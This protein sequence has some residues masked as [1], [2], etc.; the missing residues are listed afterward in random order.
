MNYCQNSPAAA[1][2]AQG[3]NLQWF[4]QQTGGTGSTTAPVPQTTIVGSTTWWVSQT[5]GGCESDRSPLTVSVAPTPAA[6]VVT[7]PYNYCQDEPAVQLVPNGTGYLWYTTQT[8]GTG[9]STAPTP[10][11]NIP[12]VYN[13]WVTVNVEGCESDRAMVTVNVFAKPPAPVTEPVNYCQGD[14]AVPL[15]AMGQNLK[16]YGQHTG[17]TGTTATPTPITTNY[18]SITYYVSQTVNGCESDRSPLLVTVY[19]NVQADLAKSK[20]KV[21]RTD[22]ASFMFTGPIVNGAVYNWNFNGASVI[23]GSGAGP[24][25]VTWNTGGTKTVSVTVTNGTCADTES[26]TITIIEAPDA[27][28]TMQDDACIG[29]EVKL[30]PDPDMFGQAEYQWNYGGAEVVSG[31]GAD[32]HILKWTSPGLKVVTLVLKGEFCPSKPF[33]DTI[34]IHENPIAKI[35]NE[36]HYNICSGDTVSL[37]AYYNTNYKY[38]WGPDIAFRSGGINEGP[39]VGAR[40]DKPMFVYLT[41]YDEYGCSNMDSTFVHSQPCSNVWLPTAF[42]PNADGRKDVYRLVGDGHILL[43]TFSIRNRFGQVV[44]ETANQYESWDGKFNGQMCDV[45][46]YFYFVRY[47]CGDKYVEKK[48]DVTLIR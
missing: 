32:Y 18:G 7:T 27:H 34:K 41:V 35:E 48:G 24:Y 37:S 31:S 30:S 43:Q 13:W 44:F 5:V 20:D 8:G 29:E 6:P 15:T 10:G 36:I 17:G 39:V 26:E 4:T 11:T 3:Q 25:V 22:T 14:P 9:M 28:F 19:Q 46:T 23:S 40:I 2:T 33:S 1:L 12:G 47:K 42:T 38:E 16:W 45:G 21:C